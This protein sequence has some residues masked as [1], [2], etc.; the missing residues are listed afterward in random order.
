MVFQQRAASVHADRP[1]TGSHG[2]QATPWSVAG[3]DDAA[4]PAS[5]TFAVG[6]F[7]VHP[8]ISSAPPDGATAATSG[9]SAAAAVHSAATQHE[10]LVAICF[11]YLKFT[12]LF[13]R[14]FQSAF[15]I[16]FY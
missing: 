9:R 11:V 10:L 4:G 6:R 8:P 14:F 15:L 5:P 12:I 16:K 7:R 3:R 2:C 13:F 1:T